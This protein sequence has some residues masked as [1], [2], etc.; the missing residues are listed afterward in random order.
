MICF[1]LKWQNNRNK[2]SL[3]QFIQRFFSVLRHGHDSYKVKFRLLYFKNKIL[4]QRFNPNLGG[5]LGV[6]FEVGRV[7]G[8]YHPLLKTLLELCWKLQI[9][10]VSTYPYIVSENIRFS[11]WTPLI[12]QMSAFFSKKIVL[13][14]Q[15]S[16][17]TRS[18]S[19]RAVL[20]TF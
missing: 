11:T 9:W 6:R 18:N 10:H 14:V 3:Q 7:G 12:L 1:V 2:I 13:F 8:I 16:N 17:F 4:H 19:V 20:E 15:K 5:L